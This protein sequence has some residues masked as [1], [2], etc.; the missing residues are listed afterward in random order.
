MR[1]PRAFEIGVGRP[2]PRI[3]ARRLHDRLVMLEIGEAEAGQAGLPGSEDF[4]AAAKAK[5][6]LGDEEPIV[7]LA[8]DVRAAP[9]PSRRAA[10]G[11][12]GGRSPASPRPT[13]PRSWCSWARPKRSACSITMIEAS[14]TSTPTSITVVATRIGDPPSTEARPWRRPSRRRSCGRGPARPRCRAPCVSIAERAP[15]PRPV[16]SPRTPRPAGRPRTPC[17][18]SPIAR[19]ERPTTSSSRSSEA[20][21]SRPACGRPASRAAARRPCRRRRSA[22]ASA[23]SASR[24]SP[25]RRCASPLAASA[26]R[27]CTPKRCCSSI[28]ASA[29]VAEARRSPGTAHACRSGCRCR[30]RRRA[31]RRRMPPARSARTRSR[32]RRFSRPVRIATAEP[33]GLGERPDRRLVLA[34]EDL[35]RRHQRGLGCRPRSPSPSPAAR[36]PSCREPTSPCSRRSIRCGSARSALISAIAVSWS[37]VSVKGRAATQPARQ[38]SCVARPRLAGAPPHMRA[39]SGRAPADRP[40]AR[41]RRAARAPELVGSRSAA[42]LGVVRFGERVGEAAASRLCFHPLRRHPFRQ[43]RDRRRPRW[44]S[45]SAAS[46]SQGPR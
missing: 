16:G 17:R 8:Q 9:S 1:G 33:G 3:L 21:A 2:G 36:R 37:P 25:E 29:E 19:A 34:R 13:R 38:C 24:S 14:G 43:R 20:P 12:G 18:R 40:G 23:G 22:P 39:A 11:R 10:A 35:G 6:L 15:P 45:P 44:R 26:R 30:A 31:G 7:G 42:D 46:S 41:H 4:A 27:C 28:T 5:I 32:S